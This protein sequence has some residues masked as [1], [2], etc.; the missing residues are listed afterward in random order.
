MVQTHS[1]AANRLVKGRT[2][3]R[4]KVAWVRRVEGLALFAFVSGTCF[5]FGYGQQ[6][7]LGLIMILTV[8]FAYLRHPFSFFKA[9]RPVPPEI[10]LYSLWVVWTGLTGFVIAV[11]TYR[12]LIAYRVL[13]QMFVMVWAVYAILR[14]VRT[15]DVVFL[16]LLIG[17]LIQAGFVAVGSRTM[18]GIGGLMRSTE[19][20]TGD[21]GNPNSLGFLMVW[22]VVCALI[23]WYDPKKLPLF[24]R[25]ALLSVILV[26]TV[27][28]FASG[29]RKSSLALV[30]VGF[31][32]VIYVR[33]RARGSGKLVF[34]LFFGSMVLFVGA[35]V[36]PWIMESTPVGRRF[37]SFMEE[38]HGDVVSSA[39]SNVRY[40]MYVEGLKIFIRHPVVGVGLNNFGRYFYTGQYSHSDYMEPLATTGLVGFML[41]QSFYFLLIVRIN[42][43]L[44]V[45]YSG[46][47]R[48]R[49]R[50]YLVGTVAIM[51]IGLGAPHYTNQPV[52]LLLVAFSVSTWVLR[53]DTQSAV[54][55]SANRR[56]RQGMALVVD[57]GRRP[58]LA[59]GDSLVAERVATVNETGDL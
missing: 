6:R 52:F 54:F 39:K 53:I 13:L 46:R 47:L 24:K 29:S 55:C 49:L 20:V 26:A 40:S 22:C 58:L 2:A 35:R 1:F 33:G 38:G 41:Y 36:G 21:T 34:S 56:A 43:L 48:Y 37:N 42:R 59:R 5:L 9:L 30:L 12:F 14:M 18:G 57:S 15:V 44:R 10:L 23:F 17:S 4:T 28:L 11:D 51:L 27:V 50:M 31:L 25:T 8:L 16:G 19:G 32:W 45:V 7:T 3:R